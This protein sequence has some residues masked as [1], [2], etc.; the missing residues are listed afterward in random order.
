MKKTIVT[1][2]SC[3]TILMSCVSEIREESILVEQNQVSIDVAQPLMTRSGGD[4]ACI[5][6]RLENPYRLELMQE[7]YDDYSM[8][9]VTLEPTDFYVCFMPQDSAQFCQLHDNP[10][11]ELFD[12][13]LDI[14]LEEGQEY[15][16]PE[17]GEN[18]MPW[19]YTTVKPGFEFPENIRYSIIDTCY[20][21]VEEES[22]ARAR[23][24][25]IDV[26]AIALGRSGFDIDTLNVSTKAPAV[27]PSGTI[28]VLQDTV[29]APLRGVKIRCHN[30][31]KWATDYTDENGYYSM[32]KSFKTKVR[33]AIV[34]DNVKDFDIWGNW[35][36]L[37]RSI[38]KM[39]KHS[40]SGHTEDI[41]PTSNAWEWSVVNNAAYDYYT[42]CDITGIT[43]P[44]QHLKIWVW[45]NMT[46]TA[47]PMIRRVY[48]DIINSPAAWMIFLKSFCT[49]PMQAVIEAALAQLIQLALYDVNIGTE[50]KNV[51]R[52][53]RSVNHELAHASHY[54]VVG[55]QYWGRYISHIV[56]N[57]GYGDGAGSNAEL[58]GI[59]E[60][61]GHAIGQI[62]EY[63]FKGEDILVGDFP[64]SPIEGWIYPDVFWDL[65]AAKTLTKKQIFDCLAYEVD[66]YDEL[67][68]KMISNNPSKSDSIKLA[69]ARYDIIPKDINLQFCP[70][71]DSIEFNNDFN[72]YWLYATDKT[73]HD[74]EFRVVKEKYFG[75]TTNNEI[76]VSK[77][78]KNKYSADVR[79]RKPGYYVIEA[80]V[81]GTDIKKYFHIAKHY[82]PEYSLPGSER[83]MG[84]E[85]LTKLGTKVGNP[86]TVHVTFGSES[87]LKQRIVALTTVNYHQTTANIDYRR[88]DIR[89]VY[90]NTDTLKVNSGVSSVVALPEI[91]NYRLEETVYDPVDT[92]IEFYPEYITFITEST[93]YYTL[94]YPDD[95]CEWVK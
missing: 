80:K 33:Y 55:S 69:F 12:Y 51:Y 27:Y 90:A 47:A 30:V 22:I 70:P 10:D 54:S 76:I 78:P 4:A 91:Y 89:N 29:N 62:Q 37:A 45:R 24:A 28:T 40:N 15:V 56:L 6:K 34:Y 13:P 48:Q 79:I 67:I 25:A 58:C 73:L 72:I 71:V 57:W 82:K 7:I 26:E 92:P 11:L 64:D 5:Y 17:L 35:W 46:A 41:L 19:L 43:K 52:I 39:G 50:G 44:P 9:P 14:E 61:W 16:N 2:S 49:K 66:T 74:I 85:P 81:S 68:D 21:P 87:I 32:G 23:A 18:D 20:I 60:M 38:Y 75:L 31:V 95:I 84:R 3:I 8:V 83:G 36:P 93:G 86:R 1:L 94:K 65:Y 59:G 77:N 88:V 63:E 42:M 53:Y